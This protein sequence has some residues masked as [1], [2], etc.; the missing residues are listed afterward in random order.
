ML[1]TCLYE[2]E[3]VFEYIYNWLNCIIIDIVNRLQKWKL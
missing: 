2:G 1:Y 3:L